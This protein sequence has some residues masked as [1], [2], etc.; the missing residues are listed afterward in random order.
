M[1]F[2]KVIVNNLEDRIIDPQ[3]MRI[4]KKINDNIEIIK[5]EILNNKSNVLDSLINSVF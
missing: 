4:I 5:N 1:L 3:L 2:L